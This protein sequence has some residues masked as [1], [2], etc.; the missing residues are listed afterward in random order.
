MCAVCEPTS[1]S[2]DI[3]DVVTD[4]VSNDSGVARVILAETGL[5]LSG[6]ISTD[7]SSLGVDTCD[8]QQTDTKTG[9]PRGR[10]RNRRWLQWRPSVVF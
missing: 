1:H 9:E 4:I 7:I 2:S 6:K 8:E 5:H 10:T 3:S